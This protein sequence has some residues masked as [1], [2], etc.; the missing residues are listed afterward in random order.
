[1]RSL[2]DECVF[3]RPVTKSWGACGMGEWF[4]GF[5]GSVGKGGLWWWAW[6]FEGG[7]GGLGVGL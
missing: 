3:N 6:W 2:P 7:F 1:M 5:E 4:D